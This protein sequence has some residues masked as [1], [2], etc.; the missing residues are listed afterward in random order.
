VNGR[1]SLFRN[2][3]VFF[4][5]E[6]CGLYKWG[7]VAHYVPQKAEAEEGKRKSAYGKYKEIVAIRFG[8]YDLTVFSPQEDPPLGWIMLNLAT[9]PILVEGP[10]DSVTWAQ[11]GGCIRSLSTPDSTQRKKAYG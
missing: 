7:E 6:L 9:G 10:L 1:A 8:A 4:E 2:L 5:T 3:Q 11:I